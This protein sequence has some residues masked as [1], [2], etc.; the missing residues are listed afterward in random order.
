MA[1][2]P[3]ASI[4]EAAQCCAPRIGSGSPISVVM[5]RVRREVAQE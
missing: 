5:L 4:S 2:P 3:L 1:T